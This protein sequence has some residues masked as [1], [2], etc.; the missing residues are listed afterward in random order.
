[1]TNLFL[2]DHL[3]TCQSVWNLGFNQKKS[4][5]SKGA[6][7]AEQSKSSLRYMLTLYFGWSVTLGKVVRSKK[8]NR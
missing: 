3:I 2:I 5:A 6:L 8:P 7:V 4:K 1:M